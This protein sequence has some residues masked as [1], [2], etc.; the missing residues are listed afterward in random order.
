MKQKTATI[1]KFGHKVTI[2]IN[3]VRDMSYEYDD[4]FL[5]NSSGGQDENE[6][7]NEISNFLDFDAATG[8]TRSAGFCVIAIDGRTTPQDDDTDVE[9]GD[10]IVLTDT[11]LPDVD[12]DAAAPPEFLL[13]VNADGYRQDE[14]H[15]AIEF[16]AQLIN[17]AGG[18][19]K[20]PADLLGRVEKQF[21]EALA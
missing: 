7:I 9:I 18:A 4:R 13:F 11:D 6:T 16:V 2:D 12:F 15:N 14:E 19:S 3:D 1:E 20:L 8:R 5:V 17:D 10:Y 21:P